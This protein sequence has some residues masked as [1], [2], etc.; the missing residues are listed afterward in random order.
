MKERKSLQAFTLIELLIVI[1]IIGILASIVLVSLAGARQRASIAV[2]KQ[3]AN[4]F[5]TAMVNMCDT[6]M[7][8]NVADIMAVIPSG[9]L[10]DGITFSNGDIVSL[11]CGPT[12]SAVFRINVHSTHLT[13][14]CIGTVEQTGVTN[15]VGC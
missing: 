6:N 7:L 12:G 2:F 1:S 5:K 15:W 8:S 13:T 11:N 3:Q 9:A 10:P 4:S 14:E